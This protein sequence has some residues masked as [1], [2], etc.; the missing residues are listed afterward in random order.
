MRNLIPHIYNALFYAGLNA[1]FSLYF[2]PF[3]HYND[4]IRPIFWVLWTCQKGIRT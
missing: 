2:S 3:N 1:I 4:I